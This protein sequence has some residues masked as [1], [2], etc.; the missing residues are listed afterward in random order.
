MAK[1]GLNYVTKDEEN[2]LI[3]KD[4]KIEIINIFKFLYIIHDASFDGI[5]EQKIIH[6]LLRNLLVNEWKEE[7]LSKKTILIN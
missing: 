7:G 4:Q 3:L 5:N 6:N 2:K 1:N